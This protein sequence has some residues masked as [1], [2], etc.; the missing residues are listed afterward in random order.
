MHLSIIIPTLNESAHIVAT[1]APLQRMRDKGAE[2]ILVDGGSGD[3]T[4]ALATPLVDRIID[5]KPG[6]ALQMNVGA[7]GATGE[8]LLFLHADSLLPEGA[9]QQIFEGLDGSQ[10]CW[11][12]FDVAIAGRHFMFLVV[13]WFMNHRSRLTGIAT[14][15]QGIFVTRTVFEQVGGFPD[16]VLMEDIEL[17]KRLKK[18][19][20]PACLHEKIITSGRRW[21]KHGV[22]RTMAL[23]WWL[24][25]RYFMG[26][27]PEDIH[28]A[29]YDPGNGS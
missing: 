8:A 14:G 27:S 3:A 5:S 2:V 19:G 26:S 7:E 28:R 1:L 20:K 16:Q 24:R 6:R 29:Y 17:C 21:E 9:D 10:H 25:L 23:M 15:D 22:W 12:R 11:G 18:S 4:K 13:A